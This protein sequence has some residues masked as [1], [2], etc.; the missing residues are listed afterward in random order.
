MK[1][2]CISAKARHGKDTAADVIKERLELRGNKV[3][4]I[5]FADLLKFICTSFFDWDGE[6]NEKGRTILQ[7]VGTEVIGEKKP[8]YWVDF[9]VDFL[10]RQSGIST[11]SHSSLNSFKKSTIKS[12]Q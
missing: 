9:I 12:T 11:K 5:H 1:V 3:L 4:T 8:F 7:H 6:K 2:C 10:N